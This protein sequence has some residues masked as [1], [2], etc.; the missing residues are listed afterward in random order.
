MPAICISGLTI[1]PTRPT[2]TSMTTPL[3]EDDRPAEITPQILLRAYAVGMFP[4]SEGAD[5]PSLFWVD[6][7]MRGI[8]P[9]DK[10]IISKSLAKIIRADR[11]E[12]RVDE[13]FDAV[14]AACAAAAPD[15]HNTWIN[16]R[17]RKLYRDL[18]DFGFVH[19][20]ET[21]LDGERVGGLYGVKIGAAFFG[22]SMFHRATDASKVALMHLA[23]R[24]RAGGF[25][26]LDTQFITPHLATLGAVE[27]PRDAY[28]VMLDDA[29][30]RSADFFVWP[31]GMH[32]PG[33]NILEILKD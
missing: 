28:H 21:F 10:M 9:L 18:F 8:F 25:R 24:L 26:L 29:I 32:V 3:P 17:I 11:F 16:K 4:M 7:E 22:E 2:L 1:A 5:D 33:A 12:V 19:T 13:D 23:A 30:G 27:V 6:P 31:K 15:R 20:V 14:I